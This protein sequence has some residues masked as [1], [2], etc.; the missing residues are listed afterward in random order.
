VA[1]ATFQLKLVLSFL[2][3]IEE[4]RDLSTK[5]G[6]FKAILEEHLTSLLRQQKSYWKQRGRV[7]W[8]K[9][10]DCS[11]KLFHA[12]ATIRHRKSLIPSIEDDSG[13]V[14]SDHNSKADVLWLSFKDRL[15]TSDFMNML[16]NIS[17]FVQPVS[18]LDFLEAPFSPLEIDRI[19]QSFLSDKSPGPDGFNIDFFKKMLTHY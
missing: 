17:E 7:K 19:V 1:K 10:G 2:G 13:M 11:T 9:Y 8:V 6:N 14:H 18:D 5:E 12:H 4:H 15:G 16:F 3:I